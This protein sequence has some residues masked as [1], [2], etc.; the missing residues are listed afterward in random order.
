MTNYVLTWFIRICLPTYMVQYCRLVIADSIITQQVSA[1]PSDWE[2]QGKKLKIPSSVP[3][4]GE[5]QRLS[6]EGVP[7][8]KHVSNWTAVSICGDTADRVCS[9]FCAF[10]PVSLKTHRF[11]SNTRFRYALQ[12]SLHPAVP[13]HEMH[14]NALLGYELYCTIW[15]SARRR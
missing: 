10:P 3:K 8:C 11:Q 1:L 2:D 7:T 5:M 6:E 4:P 13:T 9:D 12:L 15:M 14:V